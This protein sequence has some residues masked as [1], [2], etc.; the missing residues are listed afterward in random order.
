M[1]E[2]GR[3]QAPAPHPSPVPPQKRLKLQYDPAYEGSQEDAPL[4]QDIV[5]GLHA[6]DL[7]LRVGLRGEPTGLGTAEVDVAYLGIRR[8]LE[9]ASDKIRAEVELV[10]ELTV[11]RASGSRA[12]EPSAS[13]RMTGDARWA[14]LPEQ[15]SSDPVKGSRDV[16]WDEYVHP[17]APG[18][19]AAESP[20]Q[21][22]GGERAPTGASPIRPSPTGSTY[23]PL[24]MQAPH[25]PSRHLPSP[26]LMNLVSPSPSHTLAPISPSTQ[27]PISA[28]ATH[29]Q[30]LQQQV[31]IKTLALQTLQQEHDRILAV[32]SRSQSR[33]GTLEKRS[34]ANDNEIANLSEERMKLQMQVDALEAQVEELI[35]SR[36]EARLQSAAKGS[37]YTRIVSMASQLEAQSAADS[38]QWKAERAEWAEARASLSR[39]LEELET[40]AV[41]RS[42][43]DVAPIIRTAEGPSLDMPGAAPE[44]SAVEECDEDAPLPESIGTLQAE[45]KQLRESCHAMEAMLQDLIGTGRRIEQVIRRVGDVSASIV[46]KAGEASLPR[47]REAVALL[48]SAAAE[49]SET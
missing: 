43:S 10:R 41:A 31:S 15:E 18:S 28:Q 27:A 25:P 2:G 16:P 23:A 42:A 47:R 34:Q 33:C 37:Q 1:V 9:W 39:R 19:A 13:T 45:V 46:T 3:A 44:S 14:G 11:R 21:A 30:D 5:S 6:L 35:Q 20:Q 32:L 17:S 26:S 7:E 24:Q 8:S 38:K 40:G 29:L 12:R 48:P 49:T 22:L 36:D 4:V